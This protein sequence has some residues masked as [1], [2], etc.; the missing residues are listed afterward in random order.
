MDADPKPV[1]DLGRSP[2]PLTQL[3][4]FGDAISVMRTTTRWIVAGLLV[5]SLSSATPALA[6]L[7][8][9]VAL[10]AAL[11]EEEAA[12]AIN[13]SGES[14]VAYPSVKDGKPVVIVARLTGSGKLRDRQIV[15]LPAGA[16]SAIYDS[17]EGKSVS[18]ALADDGEVVVADAYKDACCESVGVATWRFGGAPPVLTKLSPHRATE[19][20][21]EP[22]QAAIDDHGHVF[23]AWTAQNPG[24][25][26]E[27]VQV[28]RSEHRGYAA[29]T[30]FRTSDRMFDLGSSFGLQ[31]G[32]S[33][34]PV[35]NWVTE[36]GANRP[37]AFAVNT[38]T[39]GAWGPVTRSLIPAFDSLYQAAS[40]GFATD[41]DGGQA[42][43]YERK[44]SQ[45]SMARRTIGGA[46]GH[47][48]HI[49]G[50]TE[51][52]AIAAGGHDTVLVAWI[53]HQEN[54]ITVAIGD[55]SGHLGPAQDLSANIPQDLAAAV[56]DRGRAILIWESQARRRDRKGTLSDVWL[57]AADANRRLGRP[58]LLSNPRG[59][60][61]LGVGE[62][63][64]V[65]S[66]NG[67]TLVF[68]K[69]GPPVEGPQ[70]S[71]M[72]RYTP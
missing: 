46:F 4:E 14:L 58:V 50:K 56:D 26:S 6:R 16:L 49:D 59:N 64:I 21:I 37:H 66:P 71:Y 5:G 20:V 63:E 44:G 42:L 1:A 28:A 53:S 45:L 7:S 22:P 57:D 8:R 39:N 31:Q 36:L 72:A 33:G 19:T 15:A 41:T 48:L 23:A 51:D 3:W 32:G 55:L 67:H 40:N 9:P 25:Q 69:C 10:P 34:R 35:L 68:W 54:R 13:D 18:V 65:A 38:E 17:A 62:R 70:T 24:E 27:Y 2:A 61:E 29:Q 47:R 52:A 60:C 30:L 11:G 12:F 43:L